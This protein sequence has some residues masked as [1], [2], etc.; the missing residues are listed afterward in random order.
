MYRAPYSYWGLAV[1]FQAK[2]SEA[3]FLN[4][5]RDTRL[6]GSNTMVDVHES[7]SGVLAVSL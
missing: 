7:V 6:W 2:V 5:R 3:Y 1:L 4:G